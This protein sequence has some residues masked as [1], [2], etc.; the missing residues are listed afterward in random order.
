MALNEEMIRRR[1]YEL[2]EQEGRPS[3]AEHRNWY[4]AVQD[5][6]GAAAPIAAKPR[7]AAAR[8]ADAATKPARARKTAK[9]EFA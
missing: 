8:K 1:A 3:G 4:Q 5:M 9:P 2:W 7:K 6:T